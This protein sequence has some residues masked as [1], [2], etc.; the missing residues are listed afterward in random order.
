MRPND[1]VRE[2]SVNGSN[3]QVNVCYKRFS[4]LPDDFAFDETRAAFEEGDIVVRRGDPVDG[5]Y[6]LRSGQAVIFEERKLPEDGVTAVEADRI[7]GVIEA[8]SG[9]PFEFSIKAV[10]RCEFGVI[11]RDNFLSRLGNEPAMCFRLAQ[12][13]GRMN[14]EILLCLTSG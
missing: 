7:Y 3:K 4:L 2:N 9:D 12:I 14:R 5:L 10:T 6:L 1:P 11:D 13:M 8:L